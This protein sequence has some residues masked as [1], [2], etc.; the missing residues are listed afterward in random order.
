MANLEVYYSFPVQPSDRSFRQFSSN[1]AL[2]WN[3]NDWFLPVV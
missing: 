3:A 2:G 1:A